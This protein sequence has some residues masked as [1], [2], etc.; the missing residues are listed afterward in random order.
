MGDG[1]SGKVM[2]ARTSTDLVAGKG[3]SASR[4]KT[5]RQVQGDSFGQLGDGTLIDK[6]TP[7]QVMSL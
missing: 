7:V 3:M 2:T 5:Q 4:T 6:A 1:L